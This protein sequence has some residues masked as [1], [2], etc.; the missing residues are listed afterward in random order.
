MR[1]RAEMTGKLRKKN[2]GHGIRGMREDGS[3][4]RLDTTYIKGTRD[5]LSGA[6]GNRPAIV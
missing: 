5:D 3:G 2:I 1:W 4:A 6:I